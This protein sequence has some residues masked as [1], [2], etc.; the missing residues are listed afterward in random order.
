MRS[1]YLRLN[2]F[3]PCM[4]SRRGNM[5]AHV[6]RLVTLVRATLSLPHA[7]LNKEP[8]FKGKS[9]R[10]PS[11]HARSR[12][13]KGKAYH[14]VRATTASEARTTARNERIRRAFTDLA[15]TA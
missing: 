13:G 10:S 12:A 15:A 8:K 4:A 1:T 3:V 6:L 9:P 2:H 14:F 5:H 7:Q 11:P